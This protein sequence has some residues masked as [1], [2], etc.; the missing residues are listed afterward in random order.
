MNR[1]DRIWE[2]STRCVL[3]TSFPL[4]FYLKLNPICL[5][6]DSDLVCLPAAQWVDVNDMLQKKGMFTSSRTFFIGFD[7]SVI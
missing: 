5:E 3:L 7:Y 6:A 1:M 2:I 4:W